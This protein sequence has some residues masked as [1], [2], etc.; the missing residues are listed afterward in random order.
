MGNLMT[1]NHKLWGIFCFRLLW[2]YESHID[3][4]NDGPG[5]AVLRRNVLLGFGFEDDDIEASLKYLE[6]L[7][8]D[9]VRVVN[10][11]KITM[12]DAFPN[13]PHVDYNG[14]PLIDL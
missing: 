10:D 8:F 14:K 9:P 4:N 1:P 11:N 6:K 12:F 5:E 3:Q 13:M 2:E 7:D